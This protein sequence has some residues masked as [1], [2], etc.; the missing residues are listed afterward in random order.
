MPI[1]IQR[2]TVGRRSSIQNRHN[3]VV[4]FID[5]TCR[6]LNIIIQEEEEESLVINFQVTH[7]TV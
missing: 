7:D 2:I 6:I 5:D 1:H 4:D 3:F